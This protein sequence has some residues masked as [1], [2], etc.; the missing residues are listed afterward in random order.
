[1]VE[2]E[3]GGWQREITIERFMCA[4]R[5]MHWLMVSIMTSTTTTTAATTAT[6]TTT[7][8]M[9]DDDYQHKMHVY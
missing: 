9:Y 4:P 3:L 8:T 6:K 1:M 7:T 2:L 5:H